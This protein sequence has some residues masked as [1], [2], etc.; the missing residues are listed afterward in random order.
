MRDK[1]IFISIFSFLLGVFIRSAIFLPSIIF[2]IAGSITI[3]FLIGYAIVKNPV[4]IFISVGVFSLGLGVLRFDY[5]DSR[6]PKDIFEEVVDEDISFKGIILSEPDRR[7]N[8]QR[9]VV[10]LEEY[11]NVKILV[12]T[13][14]F[15]EFSYGDKVS[16][17]G[18]LSKPE[19]FTTDVGKDFDYI[20]YLRKDGIFY[21]TSFASVSLEGEGYGN[22]LKRFLL[23]TKKSFLNKIEEIIESPQSSLL[24]G[25]LLGTKQSLGDSLEDAFIKTGLIHIVVLSGYNVTIIAEAIMRSLYF[26]PRMVGIGIGSFSIVAFTVMTGAGATIVRASIMAILALIARATGNAYEI[27]RGLVFAGFLMVLHNPYILYFDISFQL[28]FLATLG[29]IYLSPLFK[30]YFMWLPDIFGLRE[31]ASATIATQVFVLPFLLYKIGTLSIIAPITNLLVLPM[32]PLTMLFGF[33]TGVFGFISKVVAT[34]FGF[35]AHSLLSI[36]IKIVEF[37]SSLSFSA[38]SVRHMSIFVV[39]IIYA[40]IFLILYKNYKIKSNE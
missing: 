8:S 32:I 9:F 16:V 35:L 15:P 21:T 39:L 4:L 30:K 31:I 22:P 5:T 37:F 7:E 40:F 38:V 34:P 20:N 6:Q 27:T 23:K 13:E 26:L 33:L 12:S 14:L 2:W 17:E 10:G 3:L 1:I 24:G 25:L 29:L 19:N 18:E 11:E 28:S 36:E